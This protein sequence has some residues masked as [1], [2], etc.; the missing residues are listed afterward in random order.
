V[1]N[2][3]ITCILIF[4]LF[5]LGILFILSCADKPVL[6]ETDNYIAE[7]EVS[8]SVNNTSEVET[9]AEYAED[10]ESE[11]KSVEVDDETLQNLYEKSILFY[12]QNCYLIPTSTAFKERISCI[13]EQIKIFDICNLQEV[14]D[15]EPQ[16]KLINIFK[17]MITQDS[18]KYE[19]F[20]QIDNQGVIKIDTRPNFKDAPFQ[21]DT[22][23]VMGPDKVSGSFTNG[24][25]LILSKYP[26]IYASAFA[27]SDCSS[28]DCLANKGAIYARIK[29]GPD[30]RDYIHVFNTHLQAD[31]ENNINIQVRVNQISELLQFIK[32][33]IEFGQENSKD[34]IINP[35]I[36]M[37][38]FNLIANYPENWAE[39]ADIISAPEGFTSPQDIGNF[40]MLK[41]NKIFGEYDMSVNTIK[42]FTEVKMSNKIE[43]TDLWHELHPEQPGF[44]YIG[45]GWVTGEGNP[46]GI[47]GNTL[48][49][50][51]VIP[52]RIDYIFYFKGFINYIAQS[53]LILEPNE[54][55]Y[56][57]YQ[58]K[59]YCF[60]NITDVCNE[61]TYDDVLADLINSQ[62]GQEIKYK[63]KSC[64][65]SD[66]IGLYMKSDI[67]FSN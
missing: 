36:L 63:L 34:I 58:R 13:V 57:P 64:T 11:N 49:E 26:I 10:I 5:V 37:G 6:N 9:T 30:D 23:Y 59:Y 20:K 35:I 45:K 16:N 33:S 65:I 46:Y 48:T 50:D 55:F 43:L 4:T 17:E 22:F 18:E 21:C 52:Q 40:D 54:I 39:K 60:D 12:T 27:F 51:N 3:R 24:G 61:I 42:E 41:E 38:D 56:V 15:T 8:E 67:T 7:S 19:L 44:T 47:L 31:Y 1:K 28:Y 62:C 14:F 2:N 32:N 53:G 25:L 29:I 66:H